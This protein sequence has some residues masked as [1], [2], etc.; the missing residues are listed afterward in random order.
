VPPGG[1]LVG[2]LS[3]LTSHAGV[4]AP[5]AAGTPFADPNASTMATLLIKTEV[6]VLKHLR[7]PAIGLGTFRPFIGP[8]P[9]PA[10]HHIISSS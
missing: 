7:L 1:I 2:R 5:N 9:L 8:F 3:E 10:A 4:P 6:P